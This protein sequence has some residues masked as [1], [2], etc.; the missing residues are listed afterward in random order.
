MKEEINEKVHAALDSLDGLEKARPRPYFFTRLAARLESK[1][2]MSHPRYAV[3]LT[4]CLV[5]CLLFINVYLFTGQSENNNENAQLISNLAVQYNFG[6]ADIYNFHL[7][8][9]TDENE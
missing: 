6:S 4:S 3:V 2:E 9:T 8:P 1:N 5:I 7:N